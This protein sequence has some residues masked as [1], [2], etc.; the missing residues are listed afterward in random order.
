M[1]QKLFLAMPVYSGVVHLGTFHSI[2]HEIG[3]LNEKGIAIEIR[4]EAG[5]A[6]IAH[7]RNVFLANFLA[8][9][10]TD[11]LFVDDDVQWEPGAVLKLLGY[12]ADIVAGIYPKRSDP[13]G[14]HCR[15]K[16]DQKELWSNEQGL[17][18]VEG[19]PM[20]FTRITRRCLEKMIVHYPQSRFRCDQAP[21]GYAW[22][23][24]DNLHEGDAYYGEDYSFC[25]RW[26][27][28]GGKVWVDPNIGMGHVGNKMFW[29]N[30]GEWLKSRPAPEAAK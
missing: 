12:D 5:N 3:I 6:M 25:R 14:F 16:Q 26:F 19:V 29:G 9:D 20:G 1:T 30:F 15:Y 2:V 21:N 17:I 23:L 10:C 28:M 7:S 24:F 18:E 13:L 27:L 22:A 11:L 8:S 4:E